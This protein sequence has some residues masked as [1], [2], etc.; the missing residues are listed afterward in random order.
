MLF[1]HELLGYISEKKPDNRDVWRFGLEQGLP[2]HKTAEILKTLQN[3]RRIAVQLANGNGSAR[4]GSF[5][6]REK[7]RKVVISV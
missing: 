6:L 4:K 7:E 2:A 1:Q 5:Y 3:E